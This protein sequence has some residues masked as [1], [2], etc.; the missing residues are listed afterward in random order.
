M[1]SFSPLQTLRAS[2]VIHQVSMLPFGLLCQ[3]H[4]WRLTFYT[5]SGRHFMVVSISASEEVGV[6]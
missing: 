3:L 1:Y 2:T 6:K 5:I 4:G